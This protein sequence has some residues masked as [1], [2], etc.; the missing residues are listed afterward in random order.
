LCQKEKEKEK[1][2]K[3][4]VNNN[5]YTTRQHPPP[6]PSP[7][8]T[9]LWLNSLRISKSTL[10]DFKLWDKDGQLGVYCHYAMSLLVFIFQN[11]NLSFIYLFILFIYLSKVE[12]RY[13]TW[14][15]LLLIFFE[16]FYLPKSSF[17]ARRA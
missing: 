5:S 9:A 14:C 8:Q 16:F 15:Y 10:V 3:E 7:Q 13:T 1:E 6:K 2:K 12:R 17:G 4:G 11:K